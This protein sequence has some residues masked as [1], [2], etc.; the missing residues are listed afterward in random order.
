ME[1]Y[2]P[3][4][5]TLKNGHTPLT[6]ETKKIRGIELRARL[7]VIADKRLLDSLTY[8]QVDAMGKIRAAYLM[9]TN[10]I[11]YSSMRFEE[12]MG[13]TNG[14]GDYGAALQQQYLLWCGILIKERLHHGMAMDVMANGESLDSIARK[15]GIQKNR[16]KKNLVDSL[17]LWT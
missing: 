1:A 3:K 6:W 8:E 16:V 4:D 9:R 7:R 12:R 10:G 11:G 17:N 2:N 5:I 13:S 15:H 14:G